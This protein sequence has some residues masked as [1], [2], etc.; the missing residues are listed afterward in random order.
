MKAVVCSDYGMSIRDVMATD[1][2]HLMAIL[3]VTDVEKDKRDV[4]NLGDFI[5]QL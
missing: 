5:G 2:E 1:Y 4:M 3:R